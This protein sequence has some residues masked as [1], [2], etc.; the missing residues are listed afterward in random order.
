MNLFELGQQYQ[1][2]ADREDL[3]PTRQEHQRQ[4]IP[5]TDFRDRHADVL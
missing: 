4:G 1:T 3:D 2:L 5:G